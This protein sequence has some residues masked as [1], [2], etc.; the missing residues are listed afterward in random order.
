MR[1]LT[2]T[3]LGLLGA[4]GLSACVDEVTFIPR[5]SGARSFS[6]SAVAATGGASSYMLQAAGNAVPRG[7]A[8]AVQA[9]GGEL[10]N[11]ISQIG[12]AFAVASDANFAAR[13]AKIA[14][15]SS[16]T[17]DM[18]VQWIDPNESAIPLDADATDGVGGAGIGDDETFFPIQWAPKAVHAPEAWAVG[19]RGAGVR[20]AVI[21][22]GMR[23]THR[24]LRDNMDNVHSRSFVPGFA[25]N[26]DVGTFSH[27]THVAGI[28][29]AEDNHFGTIGIAP[30]ATIIGVKA[31]HHDSG[32]FEAVIAAIVYAATPIAQGG[33]GADII[34][35]SLGAVFPRNGFGSRDD[36][37]TAQLAVA[38]G[39][40]T[41]YAH[42]QGVTVFA[43]AGNDT[44]DFDHTANVI[45]LPAQS[46][47]VLAISALA[48]KGFA[49]GATDF[50]DPASYTDF[51]QSVIDF[52]APGGD[53]RLRI[54]FTPPAPNPNPN[55]TL[56]LMGTTI[57]GPCFVFD[58]VISPGSMTNDNGYFSAAGTSMSTPV[59]AGVAALII[60]K[61]GRIG[62]AQVAAKLRASSDDLGKP[63]N[64]DFYGLGRVNAFNAVQ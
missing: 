56:P 51:G 35:M 20:V 32:S 41:T 50:D 43:A 4:L 24:D 60:E 42:Q 64:D 25:F 54:P 3:F 26:Q 21:D 8:A 53:S 40:A 15:V 46:P 2:V 13:A 9:A 62:P 52:A 33:A 11:T 36:T 6:A 10:T 37:S 39:R 18:V 31:L 7:L 45:D 34:N 48:P 61:Y 12:V 17:R 14:G 63:G 55:C 28:I 27:A 30:G 59:A 22:G 16:V 1:F 19:A 57:I 5:S 47:H 49:L 38:L 29:A 58:L 23:N 44:L